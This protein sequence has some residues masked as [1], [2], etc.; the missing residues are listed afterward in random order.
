MKRN[1][2]YTQHPLVIEGES[3]IQER[4]VLR[5]AGKFPGIQP[6]ITRFKWIY[7][8]KDRAYSIKT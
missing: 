4:Q 8:W 1:L 2:H 3:A 5:S 6:I 7:T